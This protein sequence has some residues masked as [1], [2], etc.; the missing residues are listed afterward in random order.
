MELEHIAQKLVDLKTSFDSTLTKVDERDKTIAVKDARIAELTD[1]LV[2]VSKLKDEALWAKI[3]LMKQI[4]AE[5][6]SVTAQ[7]VQLQSELGEKSSKVKKLKQKSREAQDGLMGSSFELDRIKK[8]VDDKEKTI[9]EYEEK[10]A[11]VSSGSTGILYDIR[12]SIDYIL[13]RISEAN[14]SLRSEELV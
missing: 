10:V 9:Q 12:N 14:R 6:E 2:E 1:K 5:R 13:E 4:T 8:D 7:I 11:S 3:E